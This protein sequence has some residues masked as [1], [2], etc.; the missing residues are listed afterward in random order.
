MRKIKIHKRL[1]DELHAYLFQT[2]PKENGCFLM[3]KNVGQTLFIIGYIKPQK[4]SWIDQEENGFRPSSEYISYAVIQSENA[5][6]SLG[7]VHTHPNPSHPS[8]FSWID[9]ISNEQMFRNLE[10]L[11]NAAICSLVFST[12]GIHGIVY[13]NGNYHEIESYSILNSGLTKIMDAALKVSSQ[14]FDENQF[15]RQVRFMGKD[16]QYLLSNLSVSICGSGGIGSPLAVQLAKIGVGKINLFDVDKIDE[17]NLPRIYGANPA[18]VGKYKVDVVKRHIE[19]TTTCKV[20]AVRI[21]I[22]GEQPDLNS[23]DVIFG[24]LDN[25]TA[26]DILN[27]ISIKYA[28]PYIDAA[29]AI[30]LNDKGQVEQ[31]IMKVH[32]VTSDTPCLWCGSVLRAKQIHEEGLSLEEIKK[33]GEDGYYSQIDKQ[34]SVISLTTLVASMAVNRLF[35]IL[36]IYNEN[37]AVQQ[38]FEVST[39]MYT[40]PQIQRNEKC[41]CVK[42]NPFSNSQL[43][44]SVET[45]QY[46]RLE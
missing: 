44:L 35:N 15:D 13:E 12:K 6:C 5:D 39:G 46:E 20:T 38:V 18:D 1:Y 31:A 3:T 43:G 8:T 22:S 10:P 45:P 28:I 21:M 27:S 19:A 2:S 4:E 33:L 9:V 29:C 34:P 24:G 26:R 40:E 25:H 16:K 41:R 7:F 37:Y 30:P 11:V 32:V 42:N 14:S 36:G 23:S 17:S